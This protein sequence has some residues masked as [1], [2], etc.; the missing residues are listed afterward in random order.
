MAPEV[1]LIYAFCMEFRPGSE[2]K[3]PGTKT[4]QQISFFPDIFSGIFLRGVKIFLTGL[5]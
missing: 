4:R 5:V 3:G 2:E 1:V